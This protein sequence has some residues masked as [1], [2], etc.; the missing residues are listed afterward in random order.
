MPALA[1]GEARRLA[2]R[3]RLSS[4]VGGR[5]FDSIARSVSSL[6]WSI[7]SP[8]RSPRSVALPLR[9]EGQAFD[10]WRVRRR[11]CR[12]LI[13]RRYE[14]GGL[15]RMASRSMPL[16]ATI[17]FCLGTPACVARDPAS[18]A[19]RMDRD[20]KTGVHTWLV[21]HD[22]S[23]LDVVARDVGALTLLVPD[24]TVRAVPSDLRTACASARTDRALLLVFL[25]PHDTERRDDALDCGVAVYR[26]DA[27]L[28]I[29]PR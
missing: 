26:D 6:A 19:A 17:F 14:V 16:A 11:N 8:A 13:R 1:P 12:R 3:E 20:G 27:A 25:R 5:V 7:S 24:G 4:R 23:R 21:G 10:V 28:V 22:P 9:S 2:V 15:S 18:L 29:A